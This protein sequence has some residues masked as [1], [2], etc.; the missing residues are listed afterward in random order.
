MSLLALDEHGFLPPGHHDCSL[1][2]IRET[3]CYSAG[4]QALFDLLLRYLDTWRTAGLRVPV[5]VDGGFTTRK[6]DEPKDVDVVVDIT[7]LDLRDTAVI[8]VVQQLLDRQAVMRSFLVDVYPYHVAM[9][10]SGNNDLR[11]WFSYVKP[12]QRLAPGLG[13]AN[14]AS[15]VGRCSVE[16]TRITPAAQMP[17][18]SHPMRLPPSK[19]LMAMVRD[20]PRNGRSFLNGRQYPPM[21]VPCKSWR[22]EARFRARRMA[23]WSALR[24]IP[25]RMHS[26]FSDSARRCHQAASSS[27]ST[28]RVTFA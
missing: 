9:V 1:D 14:L 16:N 21:D 20:P 12:P 23:R 24:A 5:Y 10:A 2:D 3:F 22:T 8:A 4:R 26:A 7:Q 19:T 27:S 18:N 25:Y 11:A 6:A 28:S 17:M 13:T 15:I